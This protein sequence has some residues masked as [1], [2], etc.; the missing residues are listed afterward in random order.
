MRSLSRLLVPALVLSACATGAPPLVAPPSTPLEP[1]AL[2]VRLIFGAGADLDLYVSDPLQETVYFANPVSR[3]SG[4]RLE[5]DVLCDAPAPRVE[6]IT[7][8]A[9]L[10]GRYR[11][12][13]DHS[14]SCGGRA[15][16]VPFVV[17][18]DSEAGNRH[19]V[20]GSALPGRFAPVVLDL[21]LAA[22]AR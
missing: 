18:I 20:R 17:Q 15:S 16:E 1:G 21:E 6:A 4:G 13:V 7:F 14:G 2:R 11:I 19:E 10:P 22:P 9:A 3:A 12:G 8:P 5:A